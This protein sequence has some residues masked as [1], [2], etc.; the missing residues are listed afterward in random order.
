M[1]LKIRT[2]KVWVVY[3][4]DPVRCLWDEIDYSIHYRKL[5]YIFRKTYKTKAC[6]SHGYIK[7][8][9]VRRHINSLWEYNKNDTYGKFFTPCKVRDLLKRL[10]RHE[11]IV[12]HSNR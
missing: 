2:S 8:V 12:A 4:Y 7:F 3:G 5:R 6:I 11:R 10:A 9:L 1:K